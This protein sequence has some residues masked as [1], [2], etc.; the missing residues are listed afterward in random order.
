[1]GL[2]A[3]IGDGC[4][5]I[6][7]HAWLQQRTAGTLP[8]LTR[9]LRSWAT[10]A[11]AANPVLT[12]WK[13]LVPAWRAARCLP[14]PDP[15]DPGDPAVINHV[16]T[17]LDISLWIARM[18]TP[19][20]G[21]IAVIRLDDDPPEVYADTVTDT[22]DWYDA[23]TVDIACPA[24]HGWTWRTGRE[25]ITADGSFATLT[26]VFGPNL[27]APFS[28]CGDCQAYRTRHRM[29]PCP[30]DGT[31]WIICPVCGRRCDVELPSL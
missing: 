27:D 11:S 6:D 31:P 23:D 10:R 16:G 2:H 1:M 13:D 25:L 8:A 26:T 29:T 14:S 12:D 17:R 5:V 15:T 24:G 28:Q 9:D 21:R 7:T 22:A 4:V 3:R 19:G 30:C 20:H 18:L